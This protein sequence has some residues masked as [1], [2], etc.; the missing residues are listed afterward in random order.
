MAETKQETVTIIVWAD[1]DIMDMITMAI[2]NKLFSAKE[3]ETLD[4][5]L[6]ENRKGHIANVSLQVYDSMIILLDKYNSYKTDDYGDLS[7]VTRLIRFY[8]VQT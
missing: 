7:R 8:S 3:N 2:P 5:M 1:E 4:F 6:S